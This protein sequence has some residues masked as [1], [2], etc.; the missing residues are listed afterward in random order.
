MKNDLVTIKVKR[1]TRGLLKYI[2]G[3]T[4]ESIIDIAHNVIL[5]EYNKKQR[6]IEKY[7][8]ENK[9]SKQNK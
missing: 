8:I 2:S 9:T 1:E 3:I 4:Q 5:R 7:I 6:R